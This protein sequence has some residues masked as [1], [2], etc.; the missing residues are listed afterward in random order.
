M[1]YE[2]YHLAKHCYCAATIK[3]CEQGIYEKIPGPESLR[4]SDCRGAG[5]R[6]NP[7]VQPR[8]EPSCKFAA[9]LLAA[10]CKYSEGNLELPIVPVVK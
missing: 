2:K 6:G 7:R 3:Q 5:F 8:T 4:D 10:L 1:N 9:L